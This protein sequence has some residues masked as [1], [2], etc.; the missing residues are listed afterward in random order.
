VYF[1]K[2]REQID[3]YDIGTNFSPFFRG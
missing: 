2:R 3:Y 1:L